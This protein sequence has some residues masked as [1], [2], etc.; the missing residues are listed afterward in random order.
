M[1]DPH[2]RGQYP[3]TL[4]CG[5]QRL[6][7]VGHGP[8][9]TCSRTVRSPP[10]PLSWRVQLA[11][12]MPMATTAHVM[13]QMPPRTAAPSCSP[14]SHLW[15]PVPAERARRRH[16]AGGVDARPPDARNEMYEEPYQQAHEPSAEGLPGVPAAV[17]A[18]DSGE[19]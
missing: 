18:P 2:E 9:P 5:A 4:A 10:A 12:A 14:Q 6:P 17:L 19:A 16:R 8:K 15:A 1:T 3:Q 13:N 11:I 7:T